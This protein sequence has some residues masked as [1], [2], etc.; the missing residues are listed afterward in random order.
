MLSIF[1]AGVGVAALVL[2]L[3]GRAGAGT[4]DAVF[5]VG[6]ARGAS[7]LRCLGDRGILAGVED[8]E[9]VAEAV[10]ADMRVRR[11]SRACAP[12]AK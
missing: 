1:W 6:E 8:D 4:Y 7:L 3:L 5:A 11:L 2:L 9:V 12:E 10:P